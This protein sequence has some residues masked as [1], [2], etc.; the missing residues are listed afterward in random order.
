MFMLLKNKMTDEL[1][2]SIFQVK[3]ISRKVK[4]LLKFK[5]YLDEDIGS[6]VLNMGNKDLFTFLIDFENEIVKIEE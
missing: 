3:N 4:N 2:K 5:N 6:L 1:F